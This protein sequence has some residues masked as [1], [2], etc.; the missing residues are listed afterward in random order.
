MVIAMRDL[1]SVAAARLVKKAN[2]D[3]V[4]AVLVPGQL[5]E[6]AG[7]PS[8]GDDCLW[9]IQLPTDEDLRNYLFEP[10][11]KP[12]YMPGKTDLNLAQQYVDAMMLGP[13]DAV[14]TRVSRIFLS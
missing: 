13:N 4:F 1:N 6:V 12:Q 14:A 9:L 11:T 8:G 5:P 2:S 3:P 7:A 10:L